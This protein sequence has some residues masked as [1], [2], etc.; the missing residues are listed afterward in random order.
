VSINEEL[1]GYEETI[2]DVLGRARIGTSSITAGYWGGYDWR[3]GEVVVS[4]NLVYYYD[5]ENALALLAKIG[6]AKR[7]DFSE[8]PEDHTIFVRVYFAREDPWKC[9]GCGWGSIE[10]ECRYPCRDCF[11]HDGR[12]MPMTQDRLRE[13]LADF[14]DPDGHDLDKLAA[15]L[16]QRLQ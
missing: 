14:L 7:T 4:A 3:S 1:T 15:D 13:A 6:G 10:C 9:P 8:T 2:K 12:P 5:K 16:W 11:T